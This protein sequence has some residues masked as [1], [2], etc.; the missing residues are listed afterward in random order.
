VGPIILK[1][2]EHF[3]ENLKHKFESDV[4]HP[5]LYSNTLLKVKLLIL[6]VN[7]TPAELRGVAIA[8]HIFIEAIEVTGSRNMELMSFTYGILV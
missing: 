7:C 5:P 3:H 8:V 1:E 4:M 6:P 2:T